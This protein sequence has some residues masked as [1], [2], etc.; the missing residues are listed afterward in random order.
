MI[1]LLGLIGLLAL[2]GG[3]AQAEPLRIGTE[4]GYRPY[5]FID[6]NG[7]RAGYDVDLADLICE[8]GGFECTWVEVAFE[9]LFTGLARGDFDI[10]IGGIGDTPE[11]LEI[12]DFTRPYSDVPDAVNHFG[13]LSGDIDPESVP[14]G[15]QG[16]TIQYDLLIEN[17]YDVRSYPTFDAAI[18]ALRKG[19]VGAVFSAPRYLDHIEPPLF[20]LGSIASDDASPQIAVS[21]SKPQ[22]RTRIDAILDALRADGSLRRLD[23]IWFPRG[24]SQSL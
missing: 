8:R 23:V 12:V 15:V 21:R 6:A 3:T 18:A 9:D 4:S 19:D 24:D 14:I 13:A 1:R 20:D 17:G 22:L 7:E 5:I 16:G 10:A 2:L 11:R